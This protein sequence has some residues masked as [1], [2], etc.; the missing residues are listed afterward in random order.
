M[1]E[2]GER[3]L[4]FI[5]TLILYMLTVFYLFRLP[6]Q[7]INL[8]IAFVAGCTLSVLLNFVINLK[9]KISSHLTGIGGI[10]GLIAVMRIIN[11]T[12]PITF[13]VLTILAAGFLYWAR[14]ITGAHS[15]KQSLAGM[16]LGFV[17][18]FFSILTS[19][20]VI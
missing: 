9:W 14:T 3:N 4:P 7:F 6:M 17:T 11:L 15:I 8:T 13:L 10:L 1:D 5:F 18:I 20:L 16:M 12:A 19:Y 2:P